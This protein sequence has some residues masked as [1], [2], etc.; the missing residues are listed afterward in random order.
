MPAFSLP[1][2]FTGTRAAP[3]IAAATT[4]GRVH[5]SSGLGSQDRFGV[6]AQLAAGFMAICVCDGHGPDGGAV[7]AAAARALMHEAGRQAAAGAP[8]GDAVRAAMAAAAAAVE[9]M[10]VAQTS[11]TTAA[12]AVLGVVEGR[13]AV[14]SVGDCEAVVITSAG[15]PGRRPAVELVSRAHRTY[16]AGERARVEAAGGTVQAGYVIVNEEQAGGA[17]RKYTKSLNITRSLGDLDMRQYGIISEPH[18]FVMDAPGARGDALLLL[19]SDGL[20]GSG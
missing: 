9:K 3:P 10:D 8:A 4:C 16:D 7:A 5:T 13:L 11:G 1:Q 19:G 17:R 15:V 2:C 14:A 18:V 6:N 20:W 12:V